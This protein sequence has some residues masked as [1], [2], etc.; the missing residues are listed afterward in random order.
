MGA[1]HISATHG[2]TFCQESVVG[3]P[4]DLEIAGPAVVLAFPQLPR[5]VRPQVKL[6]RPQRQAPVRARARANELDVRKRRPMIAGEE[7]LCLVVDAGQGCWGLSPVG[8]R[9][10]GGVVSHPPIRPPG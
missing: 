2:G 8:V 6:E 3:C 4:G 10:S 1:E 7:S 5:F 9:S